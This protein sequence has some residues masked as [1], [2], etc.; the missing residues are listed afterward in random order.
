MKKVV[1]GVGACLVF[2]LFVIG[3]AGISGEIPKYGGTLILGLSRPLDSLA[4]YRSYAATKNLVTM[5]IWDTLLRYDE[6]GNLVPGLA[7]SW[8]IQDPKTIILHLREGVK[9]HDGTTMDA[10][11]VVA[12]IKFALSPEAK[13]PMAWMLD[14]VESVEELDSLTVQINLKIPNV[15]DVLYAL[16]TAI[17]GVTS[18]EAIEKYGVGLGEHPIGAGPFKL[19]SWERGSR[20]VLVKFNDFWEKGKPY[21]DRYII[22]ILPEEF[23]RLT[24]LT[25]GDIHMAYRMSYKN[26][27][28]IASME[29]FNANAFPTYCIYFLALKNNKAPFNDVRVRQALNYAINREALMAVLFGYGTP[30][31]TDIPP[32]MPGS[33]AGIEKPYPYDPDKAKQLLEEAGY[34]NGFS[35]EAIVK[36]KSPDLETGLALQ[37]YFKAIGVDLKLVAEEP[38]THWIHEQAGAYKDAALG[39]WY[40]DFPDAAGTLRAFYYSKNTPPDACCN[41]DYYCNPEVDELLDKAAQENDLAKRAEIYIEINKILYNDAPKAWLYHLKEALPASTKVKGLKLGPMF[42][43]QHLMADV[44]LDE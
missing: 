20:I 19:E 14:S 26:I 28:T 17:G 43:F 23:T 9:F 12:S 37:Q 40:P 34:G 31:I 8:E 15:L 10:G 21:L 6:K 27:A 32:S 16:G 38:G 13:S 4:Y 7:Q 22:K 11:D 36:A 2:V 25:R 39:Y 24:A 41:F 35:F 1:M 3:V 29:G 42:S 18:K 30:A 44:W 5:A 33:L